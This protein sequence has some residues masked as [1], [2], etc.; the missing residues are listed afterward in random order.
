M[1]IA[2]LILLPALCCA[3][4]PPEGRWEG[5]IRIP[6]SPLT[7]VIDL[8]PDGEHWVGSATVPGFT[9]GAA[10][11]DIV[12]QPPS[13]SFTLKGALGDPKFTGQF[14]A[15][16]A[17]A[18]T[19]TQ[20][21]NHAAFQL[22]RSGAAQVDLPRQSTPVGDELEGKWQG[23]V[24]VGANKLKASLELTN[25]ANGRAT[26][27]FVVTGKRELNIPVDLV[28]QDGDFLTVTCSQYR[29]SFEGQLHKD[30][31]ELT[32]TFAQGPLESPMNLRRPL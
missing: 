17:L 19:F 5:T 16:G 4:E 24:M 6:G 32:G 21:G 27:Q 29:M 12:I 28:R 26:A 30:T 1:R 20:A 2:M 15:G 31:G 8:A 22:R 9:K 3:A 7:A 13:I 14:E 10:L 11:A 25:H 23:D 18:G